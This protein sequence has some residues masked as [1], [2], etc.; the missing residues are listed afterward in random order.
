MS[1]M[2]KDAFISDIFFNMVDRFEMKSSNQRERAYV[3]FSNTLADCGIAKSP[4]QIREDYES[5]L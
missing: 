3:A 5:R 4:K 1:E 2:E